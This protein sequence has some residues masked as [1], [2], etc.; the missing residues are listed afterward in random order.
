MT[1]AEPAIEVGTALRQTAEP[2]ITGYHDVRDVYE[3]ELVG[4]D[5]EDLVAVFMSASNYVLGD[6]LMFRGGLRSINICPRDIVRKA[7]M[8]NAAA[9]I[10]LHNHPG[11]DPEPTRTDLETTETIEDRLDLFDI[12]LLDHVIVSQHGCHSM[13][14]EGDL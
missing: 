9:V 10:L 7:L 5:Q 11:G 13:T 4:R 3:D 8:L 1:D 6:A 2:K 14:R 12:K